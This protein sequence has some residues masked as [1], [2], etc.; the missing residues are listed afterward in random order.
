MKNRVEKLLKEKRKALTNIRIAKTRGYFNTKISKSK[1]RD[2][3]EKHQYRDLM[4]QRLKEQK[5]EIERKR[6]EMRDNIINSKKAKI[7]ENRSKKLHEKD[8]KVLKKLEHQQSMN[9]DRERMERIKGSVTMHRQQKS[10]KIETLNNVK[11]DLNQ[12]RYHM[13]NEKLGSTRE[14][15]MQEIER[16]KQ[17]EKEL[18]ENLK[19]TLERQ[20]KIERETNSPIKF[21]RAPSLNMDAKFEMLKSRFEGKEK[22][23]KK[24]RSNQESFYKKNEQDSFERSERDSISKPVDTDDEQM[25]MES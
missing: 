10:Q 25:K 23:K 19:Q 1:E 13:K 24:I 18:L 8:I 6:K 5:D 3:T 21:R 17:K 20:D 4:Q 15:H 16:L 12:I 2:Y 14:E 9:Q 11:S 7:E 22:L